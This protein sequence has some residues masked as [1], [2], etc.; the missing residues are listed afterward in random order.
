MGYKIFYSYQSDISKKLNQFFIREAIN[1]AIDRIKDYDIEPLIEGFYGKGGNPPLA[2]TMLE[3]SRDAD[4]FIGDVT[5]TSSKIWQS[6]GVAFNEDANSY[7]IEIE[8]PVDLNPAPNP[9]VLLETGYSWNNF[10]HE[11]GF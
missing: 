4:I 7:L 9:N 5:F 1:L 6:K 10:S 11:H 8:K 3:Q 2:E